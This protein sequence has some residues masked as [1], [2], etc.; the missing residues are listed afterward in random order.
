MFTG[1]QHAALLHD[2]GGKAPCIRSRQHGIQ[3]HF[4]RTGAPAFLS[5]CAL[6][7]WPASSAAHGKW[8]PGMPKET[9]LLDA[10]Q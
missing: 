2:V 7:A 4:S 3:T 1:N 6:P 10:M 5:P 9:K 8:R